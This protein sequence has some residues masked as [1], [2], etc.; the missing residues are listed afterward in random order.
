MKPG[1]G[2]SKQGLISA[3]RRNRS[4]GMLTWFALITPALVSV[5]ALAMDVGRIYAMENELER[6]RRLCTSCGV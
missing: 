2:G 3:W 1:L 4:G 5:S 6:G